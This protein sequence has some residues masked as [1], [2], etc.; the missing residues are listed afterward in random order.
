MVVNPPFVSQDVVYEDVRDGE[1]D[2]KEKPDQPSLVLQGHGTEDHT[3][4]WNV[5]GL[6][7]P[8]QVLRESDVLSESEPLGHDMYTTFVSEIR[9]Q[10]PTTATN[11]NR[12]TFG[13]DL[14]R[15]ITKKE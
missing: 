10:E 8:D 15:F 6:Q 1:T 5:R 13:G 7:L 3:E 12:N 9:E 2:A 11:S 4:Q 14:N